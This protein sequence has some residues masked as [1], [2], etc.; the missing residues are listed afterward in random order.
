MQAKVESSET[1]SE[2]SFNF[3]LKWEKSDVVSISPEASLQECAQLM[4]DRRVGS[5]LVMGAEAGGELQGIVTDRDIA[6]C[7]ADND[8]LSDFTVSDIMSLGVISASDRDDFF[9]LISLMH[10]NGVGRLP[11]KDSSG[12]VTGVVTSK[13]LLEILVRSLFELTEISEQ[14]KQRNSTH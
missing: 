12:R 2:K 7:L 6:L 4:K 8:Q 1:Q 14:Q 10:Q 11:L 3:N 13:N 5:V 9:K